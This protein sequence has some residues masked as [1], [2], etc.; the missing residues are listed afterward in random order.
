MKILCQTLFDCSYTGTTG[1]FRIDQVPYQDEQGQ[2]I[3]SITDWNR[4]R[5]QQRNFETILQM[6]SLRAQPEILSRPQHQENSWQFEFAV[7]A[8]GVYSND[9]T[10]DST[11]QL[12][13][14]CAGTP[15]ITG[16]TEQ[17]DIEPCLIV[18]GNNQNIWFKTINI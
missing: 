17:S 13:T 3:N 1:H 4:S 7:E 14:E 6:I 8:A 12:L 2:T 18:Q 9:G 11:A 10:A 16:L 15:M 5:N